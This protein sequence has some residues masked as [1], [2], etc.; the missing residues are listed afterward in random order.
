MEQA[1]HNNLH[2]DILAQLKT[3][4]PNKKSLS[5][6]IVLGKRI[7]NNIPGKTK[8]GL[9]IIGLFIK[10]A[11]E[12]GCSKKI[13]SYQFLEDIYTKS[14]EKKTTTPLFFFIF[15]AILTVVAIMMVMYVKPP[16]LGIML[17]VAPLGLFFHNM[18]KPWQKH[19]KKQTSQS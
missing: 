17:L 13:E 10:K 19:V 5:K 9:V 6:L 8:G 14:T 15:F 16:I 2:V 7:K 18:E 12:S 1:V 3:V 11:K 4:S